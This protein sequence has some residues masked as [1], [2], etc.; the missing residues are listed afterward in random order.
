MTNTETPIR[1]ETFATA[2]DR[3]IIIELRRESLVLRLKNSREW[4]EDQ[5]LSYIDLWN[6]T[7]EVLDGIIVAVSCLQA[8]S[9]ESAFG[10]DTKETRADWDKM[11]KASDWARAARARWAK[12]KGETK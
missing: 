9:V 5:P 3:A 2:K 7:P 8:G 10:N 1:R 12:A 11:S 6:L 4:R